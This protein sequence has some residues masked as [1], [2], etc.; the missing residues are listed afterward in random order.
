MTINTLAELSLY[1]QVYLLVCLSVYL[2]QGE[3]LFDAYPSIDLLDGGAFYFWVVLEEEHPV[4]SGSLLKDLLLLPERFKR[5]H[6]VCHH[7]GKGDMSRAWEEVCT[8]EDC[9][10]VV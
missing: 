9:G 6:V 7:P 10:I 4:V 3:G 8:E 1:C 2:A 5:A